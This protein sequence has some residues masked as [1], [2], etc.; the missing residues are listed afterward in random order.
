MKYPA[1]I[2]KQQIAIDLHERKLT[3]KDLAAMMGITRQT[4]ASV[5]S[6]NQ[7][8]SSKHATLFSLALG[9]DKTYLMSGEG[10]L[11]SGKSERGKQWTIEVQNKLISILLRIVNVSKTVQEI[12]LHQGRDVELLKKTLALQNACTTLHSRR[13]RRISFSATRLC[14]RQDNWPLSFCPL[15]QMRLWADISSLTVLRKGT[16]Y[17]NVC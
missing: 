14:I 13:C 4:V 9:Y 16:S 6:S 17:L 2:V 11:I 8:F 15:C 7:Y 12:V 5:L 10:S 3:Q 1:D